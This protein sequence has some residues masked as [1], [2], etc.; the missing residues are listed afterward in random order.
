MR[1]AFAVP[2][3][4][5]L[6]SALAPCVVAVDPVTVVTSVQGAR[7]SSPNDVGVKSDGTIWFID[8]ARTSL[9]AVDTLVRAAPRGS[10]GR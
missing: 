1:R 9:Y 3:A 8:P 7:L 4:V 6:Q 5:S 10:A 2:V